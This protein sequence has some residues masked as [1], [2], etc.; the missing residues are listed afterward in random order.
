MEATIT[1]RRWLLAGLAISA[2][3]V[4][5]P[6]F[7]QSVAPGQTA[8]AVAPSAAK[9]SGDTNANKAY[10]P[11]PVATTYRPLSGRLFF[12]DVER[13]RLD[14]ARRD[15]IQV[16][17]GDVIVTRDPKLN[18]FVKQSGGNSTY[19][20]DSRSHVATN[21]RGAPE[22]PR[23]MVGKDSAVKFVPS[24]SNTAQVAMPANESAGKPS[25]AKSPAR[26]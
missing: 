8:A 4:H 16:V 11:D 26:P 7:A 22:V 3:V 2:V 9:N 15:G 12:S 19:W 17:Q 21:E 20:V 10:V 25:T 18:G 24:E 13:A 1:H 14:K 23:S 6:L 5:G